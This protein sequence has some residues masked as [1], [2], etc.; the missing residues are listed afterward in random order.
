[1]SRNGR[2]Q[3][4]AVPWFARRG[5]LKSVARSM[6]TARAADVVARRLNIRAFEVPT[7][8]KYF[9]N[10]MD[11]PELT[12]LLCGE[13]SFGTSSDHLREKDGIWAVLAWLS[14]LAH[15]NQEWTLAVQDAEPAQVA[16]DLGYPGIPPLI[17]VDTI[18]EEHWRTFGRH[19]SMRHDYEGLAPQRAKNVMNRLQQEV[20]DYLSETPDSPGEHVM[21]GD[22]LTAAAKH[23]LQLLSGSGMFHYGALRPPAPPFLLPQS[24][25][26]VKHLPF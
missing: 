4:L 22:L 14:V 1:L 6:P 7:G 8:W 10:L 15:R 19:Y 13:E 11:T 25:C 9:G 21:R 18:M 26:R 3:G 20:P 17:G 24:T 2:G 5:G 16:Q 12:P 23:N